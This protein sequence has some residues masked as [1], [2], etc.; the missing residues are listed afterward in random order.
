MQKVHVEFLQCDLLPGVLLRRR[1]A[2][3]YKNEN[4]HKISFLPR[5]RE[6]L[7]KNKRCRIFGKKY[8]KIQKICPIHTVPQKIK[9]AQFLGKKLPNRCITPMSVDFRNKKMNRFDKK[10][11]PLPLTHVM[12]VHHV[13]SETEVSDRDRKQEVV[14]WRRWDDGYFVR[15]MTSEDVAIVQKW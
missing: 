8:P 11:N 7:P 9:G 2:E 12:S 3:Q 1:H 5:K 14:K 6:N 4:S 10:G 15:S 13:I